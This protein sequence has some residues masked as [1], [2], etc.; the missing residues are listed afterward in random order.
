MG[1]KCPVCGRS[2]KTLKGVN[3]HIAK[4]HSISEAPT[5][6][7]GEKIEVLKREGNYIEVKIRMKKTL[8]E[9]INKRAAEVGEKVENLV[10][11]GLSD[12]AVYGSSKYSVKS[13]PAYIG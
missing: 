2:F 13:E 7:P 8:W 1:Y 3:I 9:D 4:S 11:D 6:Y 10:F 5:V 12:V